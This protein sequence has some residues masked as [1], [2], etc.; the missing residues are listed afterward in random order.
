MCDKDRIAELRAEVEPLRGRGAVGRM[1]DQCRHHSN[2]LSIIQSREAA[3]NRKL[4]EVEAEVA[5][6]KHYI[7]EEHAIAQAVSGGYDARLEAERDSLRADNERLRGI[8]AR[9]RDDD[10][11][12]QVAAQVFVN[13]YAGQ[14][15]PAMGMVQA[16]RAAVLS[17]SPEA[18]PAPAEEGGE[19]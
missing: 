10:I 13:A 19:G 6:L 15:S 11:V 18:T 4:K 9:L 2:H 12:R 7:E 3:T 1:V 16:Y 5:R 14:I 8:E 17:A